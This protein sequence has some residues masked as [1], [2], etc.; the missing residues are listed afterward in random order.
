MD[1]RGPDFLT[2]GR[3]CSTPH[4]FF[5]LSSISKLYLESIQWYIQDQ[6]CSPSNDLA[7]PPPPPFLFPLS[8]HQVVS[9]S[10]SSCV[11]PVELT[12][13][14]WGGVGEEPYHMMAREHALLSNIQYS[15]MS[16][17][18]LPYFQECSIA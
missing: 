14:R 2:V 15:K 6:A 12:D 5:S 1:Y 7:S 3:L 8:Y 16:T 4:P 17:I 11:S 9:L 13:G 18:L 10:Q